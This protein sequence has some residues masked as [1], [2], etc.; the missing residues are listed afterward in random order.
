MTIEVVI[1]PYFFVLFLLY[2][3]VHVAPD[4]D[5]CAEGL[6]NCAQ[7]CTD[8]PTSYTCSCNSGY[9]LASDGRGCNGM[10]I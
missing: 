6:D 5:E 2:I 8:T 1:C 7:S 9:R 3:H 4:I 10:L